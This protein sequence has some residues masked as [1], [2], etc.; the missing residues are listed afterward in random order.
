M[1]ISKNVDCSTS[2]LTF[3]KFDLL[4][5][6]D[7][8]KA[9]PYNQWF[10]SN[11]DKS[12]KVTSSKSYHFDISHETISKMDCSASSLIYRLNSTFQLINSQKRKNSFFISM[13]QIKFYE[14]KSYEITSSKYWHLNISHVT[15]SKMW[16]AVLRVQYSLNLTFCLTNGPK[17]AT[18]W[19]W[20]FKSNLDQSYEVTSSKY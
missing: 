15:I 12:Y 7:L 3:T 5:N 18:S 11:L 4:A 17:K 19:N 6:K 13:I 9:T 16:T 1:T 20:W 14:I 8:K 10:K 2:S